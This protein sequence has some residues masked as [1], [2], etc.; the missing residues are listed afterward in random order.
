MATEVGLIYRVGGAGLRLE[1]GG[2]VLWMTDQLSC[3][4]I[5]NLLHFSRVPL[6]TIT[7]G[8]SENKV[9]SSQE[10]PEKMKD[11]PS[12]ERRKQSWKKPRMRESW[13]K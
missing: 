3:H 11:T 4:G 13:N 12:K 9:L 8:S 6:G 2:G 1:R 10:N 7:L 5:L